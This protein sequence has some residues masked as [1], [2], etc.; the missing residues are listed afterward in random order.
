MA[1]L[2]E[3]IWLY[4]AVNMGDSAL[5]NEGRLGNICRHQRDSMTFAYLLT[6]SFLSQLARPR[7]R[8]A[9]AASVC[10]A[11]RAWATTPFTYTD[12]GRREGGRALALWIP[13]SRNLRD[14]TLVGWRNSVHLPIHRYHIPLTWYMTY[15]TRVALHAPK[16]FSNL[17]LVE[18]VI[19]ATF[20][21]RHWMETDPLASKAIARNTWWESR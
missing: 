10:N 1:S 11:R 20:L 18:P 21:Y 15:R 14:R 9:P 3:E 17:Y 8:L 16:L 4:D 13:T 7:P 5:L 12:R 2:V 6:P 19:I